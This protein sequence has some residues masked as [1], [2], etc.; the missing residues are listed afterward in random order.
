MLTPSNRTTCYIH[1][2]TKLLHIIFAFFFVNN[3]AQFSFFY[4]TLSLSCSLA[5]YNNLFQ[6]CPC[7]ATS[8]HRHCSHAFIVEKKREKF[9]RQAIIIIHETK[10]KEK[11]KQR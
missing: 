1:A 4:L 8:T 9:L 5:T 3:K 10:K 6:H 2:V 7:N 11:I